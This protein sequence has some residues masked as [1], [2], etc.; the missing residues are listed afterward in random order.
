MSDSGRLEAFQV[1]FAVHGWQWREETPSQTQANLSLI[2]LQGQQ[3]STRFSRSQRRIMK[4]SHMPIAKS[5]ALCGIAVPFPKT[6]SLHN[7]L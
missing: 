5:Q 4:I 1:G 6:Y 3:I 2:S 7:R